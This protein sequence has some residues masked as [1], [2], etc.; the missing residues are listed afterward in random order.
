MMFITP[1]P[2]TNSEMP[3]TLPSRIERVLLTAVAAPIRSYRL[4]IA[5]SGSVVR[6]A[7]AALLLQHADHEETEGDAAPREGEPQLLPTGSCSGQSVAATFAPGTATSRACSWCAG[8]RKSP[9][10]A[11]RSRTAS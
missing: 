10:A 2:P 5:K 8:A 1:I 9:A 6:L 3:A 4:R 11:A 7:R